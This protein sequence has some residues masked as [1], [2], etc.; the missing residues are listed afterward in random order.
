M[1]STIALLPPPTPIVPGTSAFVWD[2]ATTWDD[3]YARIV[4][5]GGVGIVIV[6][7]DSG[8]E[9]TPL[10]GG[11]TTNL[12]GI[13]FVGLPDV[14]GNL[15]NI[16]IDSLGVGGFFL[17]ANANIQSKDIYWTTYYRIGEGNPAVWQFDG[18][19]IAS[20]TTSDA[21]KHLSFSFILHNRAI[22][23]GSS[24]TEG[25]I[26]G[27]NAGGSVFATTGSRIGQRVLFCNKG[28][29]VFPTWSVQR[30]ASVYLDP[31]AFING[32]GGGT[33][34]DPL[35]DKSLF[36]DP[37][38]GK[39]G[40]RPIYPDLR[41]GQVYFDTDLGRPIWWDGTQWIDAAGTPV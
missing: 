11:G 15:P 35:M 12:S 29:P 24:C 22:V 3:L 38:V 30:D 32:A 14:D 40:A 4:A 18:G 23:D 17:D 31:I 39:T 20:A 6:P 27:T 41:Q 13:L 19:G 10:P 16:Q 26:T 33:I 34:V 8:K 1:P 9:M 28:V 25:L 5:S 21:Y 37:S 2:A 36:V 7:N